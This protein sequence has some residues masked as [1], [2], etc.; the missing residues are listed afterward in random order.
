MDDFDS[1]PLALF[2]S[3]SNNLPVQFLCT[4]LRKVSL[5][6]CLRSGHF[7]STRTLRLLYVPP[8]LKMPKLNSS[9][10]TWLSFPTAV[11]TT[12]TSPSLTSLSRMEI[13]QGHVW[14]LSF[15]SVP[16][17]NSNSSQLLKL[18]SFSFILFPGFSSYSYHNH[19]DSTPSHFIPRFCSSTLLVSLNQAFLSRSPHIWNLK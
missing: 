11:C 9:P 12:V 8:P 17:P 2:S 18:V 4:F 7:H 13:L 6:V 1:L 16:L 5:S 15:L 19:S 10:S 14:F 3:L